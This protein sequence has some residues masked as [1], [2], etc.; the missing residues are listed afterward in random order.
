MN[1]DLGFVQVRTAQEVLDEERRVKDETAAED[2]DSSL[3]KT[4][5]SLSQYVDAKWSD[6][7]DAKTI[8][9]DEMI[10]DMLQRKG[11]YDPIKLADIQKA[12]QP[13]I[14]MN[15]TDTKC[16]NAV[17]WIKDTMFIPGKRIFGVEPT[18][19]PELPAQVIQSIQQQVL[20]AQISQAAEMF[21]QTGQ[22]PDPQMIREQLAQ[23]SEEI[24]ENVRVE[25][26]RV[27]KQLSE[28]ISKKIDDDW[29]EGGYYEALDRVIDDIVSLKAGV[30]KGP[31]FRKVKV[32]KTAISPEGKLTRTTEDRIV[33]QYERRSPFNI[34]PSPRSTGINNGYLFDVIVLRPKQLFDLIGVPG[35]NEKAIRDVLKEFREGTLK[36]DWLGLSQSALDG[37]GEDD[38]LKTTNQYPEESIYCL[39]LWDEVP[40]GLLKEW[41]L[42]VEDEDNEYSCCCWKIGD[43]VIKAMLNYD[44]LGRKPYAKASFQEVND[45]FWGRNVPALIADCQQV[46][47]S[48]AR[49]I[50]A[51]IG[52]GSLPQI[53]LNVDRLEP[54]SPKKIWP[55]RIWPVTDEQMASGSKAV[56]FFQPVMITEKLMNVYQVFS[57]IADEHSGVPAY[58]HGD[59]QVGGA[60]NTAS[61]LNMMIT[62]A[63]RGIKAVIRNIDLYIIEPSL[64]MHYDYLLDNQDI[65]GLMGDYKMVAKGTS[66]L[67]QKEQQ[68]TRKIEF[69]NN[70]ANPID[71]QIIGPEN[72]R[73]MLFEVAKSL[74]IELDEGMPPQP[75]QQGVM[76]T[77]QDAPLEKPQTL[78][79]AGNPAQG[80]EVMQETQTQPRPSSQAAPIP[81]RADGGPVKKGQ[82]YIVG[83]RGPEVIVPESNGVVVPNA[84]KSIVDL[85]H[86]TM[87]SQL[88]PDEISYALDNG[89]IQDGHP[90]SDSI[91]RRVN[92]VRA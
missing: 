27:S 78:D 5:D 91:M 30:M 83:E 86:P 40:G 10:A 38:P 25:I 28:D 76:R 56:D 89:T 51:N 65:Y 29:A 71:M 66:Y 22:P 84:K 45:S 41:G 74:G 80:V 75:P 1:N 82:P 19:I 48:C 26:E 15:I 36:N 49:N 23:N 63:A 61:G 4:V 39:E 33:P 55:G 20:K 62:Q 54:N 7:K 16:R 52:I 12:E 34:Y 73:R 8:V 68:A 35:Y 13:E 90:I 18:P 32:K 43:Y 81:G 58:A 77:Q 44:I 3:S 72:R 6:A 92:G 64:S 14:F 59:S 79:Q 67:I 85:I 17:A 88:T 87:I 70:T 31:V 53:V 47:N 2:A 46:C 57:K 37:M 42:G 11:E 69:M 21:M 50:L 24:K 9:E 60:G